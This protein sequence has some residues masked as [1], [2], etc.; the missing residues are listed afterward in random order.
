M[1]TKKPA[2]KGVRNRYGVIFC[3][4][5]PRLNDNGVLRL[6]DVFA[7]DMLVLLPTDVFVD[8]STGAETSVLVGILQC[9]LERS[10]LFARFNFD[11]LPLWSGDCESLILGVCYHFVLQV[12]Q[13]LLEGD[14]SSFNL[15]DLVTIGGEHKVSKRAPGEVDI[16]FLGCIKHGL[17]D[18]LPA[19]VIVLDIFPSWIRQGTLCDWEETGSIRIS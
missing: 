3:P 19:P 10:Y 4:M 8:K 13:G 12:F 5:R 17:M 11:R 1:K 2:R 6:L 18:C 16:Y 15:T 14:G 9:S 7:T